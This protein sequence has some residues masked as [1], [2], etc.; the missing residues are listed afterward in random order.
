MQGK[1]MQGWKLHTNLLKLSLVDL[2]HQLCGL[3]GLALIRLHLFVIIHFL[4]WQLSMDSVQPCT[5]Q[6]V[7]NFPQLIEIKDKLSVSSPACSR[8]TQ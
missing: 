1:G 2:P 7:P 6:T 8:H 5:T 4:L 3:G